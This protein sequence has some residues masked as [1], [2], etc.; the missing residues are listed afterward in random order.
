MGASAAE[1]LD[2]VVDMG[3][4]LHTKSSAPEPAERE[5]GVCDPQVWDHAS[6][7]P[8]VRAVN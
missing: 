6:Y 7:E 5:V 4:G 3:F 8:Q 2:G 1:R